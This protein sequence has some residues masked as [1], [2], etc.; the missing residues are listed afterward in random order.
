MDG[1]TCRDTSAD[2]FSRSD[3]L[4]KGNKGPH[5]ESFVR[6]HVSVGARVLD[7]GELRESG[8]RAVAGSEGEDAQPVALFEEMSAP[9]RMSERASAAP[10]NLKGTSEERP[11]V[12][13]RH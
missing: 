12:R 8:R 5:E 7:D 3:L 6:G 9:E 2:S 1:P 10:E 4:R 13:C 11:S